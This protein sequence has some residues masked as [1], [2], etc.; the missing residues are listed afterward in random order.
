MPQKRGQ[1]SPDTHRRD[2]NALRHT[3]A[4]ASRVGGVSKSLDAKIA[5]DPDLAWEAPV[6]NDPPT[7][8]QVQEIAD[9]LAKISA[10]L[11]G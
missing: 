11:A 4:N 9:Q 1:V 8:D 3:K 10:K 2:I 6:I 7:W 5:H